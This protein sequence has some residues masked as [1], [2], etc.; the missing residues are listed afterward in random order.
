[1]PDRKHLFFSVLQK[2]Y[3][4]IFAQRIKNAEKMQK[5]SP[6]ARCRTDCS[7]V[8]STLDSGDGAPDMTG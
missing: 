4:F 5:K 3:E 8:S 6:L 2:N 7:S 1:V